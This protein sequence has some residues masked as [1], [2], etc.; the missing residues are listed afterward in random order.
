MSCCQKPNFVN[1]SNS[2]NTNNF[3]IQ[4]KQI[5]RFKFSPQVI[6]ELQ[7]FA[8]IHQFDDRL[9]FK[10]AWERWCETHKIL[11][12]NEINRLNML[13]YDGD[14]LDKMFKSARYYYRKKSLNEDNNNDKLNLGEKG[15][16]GEK[17]GEGEKGEKSESKRRYYISMNP[18][19]LTNMDYH[20][21]RNIN[22]KQFSPAWGFDD[23]CHTHYGVLKDEIFRLYNMHKHNQKTPLKSEDISLKIKKTYKNRYYQYQSGDKKS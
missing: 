21:Q 6:T 15:E 23:F 7:D 3:D 17:E 1:S 2:I 8:K 4:S 11:I 12:D 10:T 14:I 13:N 20:I 5:Y 16:K 9:V 19:V 22:N 18:I